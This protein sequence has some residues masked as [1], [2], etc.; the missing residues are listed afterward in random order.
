MPGTWQSARYPD[1]KLQISAA[2]DGETF[3]IKH[4]S[5]YYETN[6]LFTV[7]DADHIRIGEPSGP[8]RTLQVSFDSSGRM[9]LDDPPGELTWIRVR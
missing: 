5:S 1:M 2:R 8:W 7:V 9:S 4:H 6:Y 3:K